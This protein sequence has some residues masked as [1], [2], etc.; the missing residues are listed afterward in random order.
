M[1]RVQADDRSDLNLSLT[2]IYSCVLGQ[3]T[4]ICRREVN[5]PTTL[6]VVKIEKMYV[7]NLVSCRGSRNSPSCATAQTSKLML[8]PNASNALGL[9][10]GVRLCFTRHLRSQTQSLTSS[11]VFL[12]LCSI[13]S[14][15]PPFFP[16]SNL[17]SPIIYSLLCNV[18]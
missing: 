2:A 5:I 14:I 16:L 12:S 6:V 17:L 3:V 13:S 11:S 1:L 8:L 9:T 10:N 4:N 15:L 7:K 18:Q